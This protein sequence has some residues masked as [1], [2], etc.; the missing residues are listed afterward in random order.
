MSTIFTIPNPS[1]NPTPARIPDHMSFRSTSPPIRTPA[2]I[3]TTGMPNTSRFVFAPEPS[4][5]SNSTVSP[6]PAPTL[7]TANTFDARA[8]P[9]ADAVGGAV[10]AL[11]LGR[12]LDLGPVVP[13]ADYFAGFSHKTLGNGYQSTRLRR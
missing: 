9:V 8:G 5:V 6:T 7:F 13:G 4:V 12:D 2:N 11:A 3:S 1:A 10:L